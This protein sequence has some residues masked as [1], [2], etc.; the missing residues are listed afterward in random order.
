[1]NSAEDA[2]SPEEETEIERQKAEIALLA[3]EEEE[4]SKKQFNSGKTGEHQNLSTKKKQL[5]KK[6]ALLE[7]EVHVSNA[8]LQVMSTSY[9]LNL[10]SSDPNFSKRNAMKKNP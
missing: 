3:V 4:D 10:D 6:K 7:D 9:L 8:R 5:M 2:T 1:M